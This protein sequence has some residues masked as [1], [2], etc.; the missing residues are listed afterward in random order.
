MLPK[1]KPP[2]RNYWFTCSICNKKPT[3]RKEYAIK[4]NETKHMGKAVV[5]IMHKDSEHGSQSFPI[6]KRLNK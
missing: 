3:D 6:R 4:H 5:L 1:S 2:I